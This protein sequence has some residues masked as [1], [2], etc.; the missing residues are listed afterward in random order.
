MNI[1]RT[2]LLF[3]LAI[4]IATL[5][6]LPAGAGKRA[7]QENAPLPLPALIHDG[8]TINLLCGRTYTGPLNLIGKRNVQVKTAGGCGK[9]S[10]APGQPV[11]GWTHYRGKI[12]S[13]PIGFAPV[14]VALAG[15]PMAL[16]HYPDAPLTWVKGKRR[17]PDRLQYRWP[18]SDLRGAALVFRANDWLIETRTIAGHDDGVIEL[19]PKKGDAFDLNPETEFYVEGKLWMLDHPGEWAVHKGRLY[20][21]APDGQSPEGRAW[22]AP[23]SAGIDASDSAN[24]TIDGLRILSAVTG[25]DGSNSTNLQVLN[26]DIHDSLEDGIFAGGSGLVVHNT[27]IVNS[28][29]NGI[30]G[31]YGITRS[32]VSNSTI[33]NTGMTGMPKRSKGAIVFEDASGQR[34]VNNKIINSSYIA[35]RVHKNASVTG[36]VI[37]GACLRL[38]DCGGIYT[39]AR[40]RQPSNVRIE[41]NTIRNLAQRMAHAVYLDDYANGVLV[42]KNLIEHNPGGMQIHNGF[43][44]VVTDNIFS[45]SA[46]EHVLFNETGAAAS[47]RG[48]RF[49]GNTFV[50]ASEE[51]TYRLW[52]T[53]GAAAVARFAQYN[54]NT[55]RT[56]K[57][58]FAEVSG[59]GMIS[60]PAWQDRMKQDS[61]SLMQSK[62]SRPESK[63]RHKPRRAAPAE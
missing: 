29:Q 49:S 26:S 28:M 63:A 30:H 51:A 40:D 62:P 21:W 54:D 20:L 13:A 38:T 46:F 6:A 17:G 45:S 60:Y 55:Y 48:N 33:M 34:I 41:G 42:R 15:A 53:L 50:S 16:A 35:I 47:I 25:I 57:A 19:A 10:I 59:T 61:R 32:V 3:T 31:Y 11:M 56:G 4:I 14:Q 44:N 2:G 39:F 1:H 22:A 8:M 9:A 58:A 37:D 12:F 5:P 23:R 27:T 43:D 18:D 36:N 7:G 24:I 52:S